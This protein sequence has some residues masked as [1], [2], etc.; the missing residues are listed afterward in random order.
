[1][2]HPRAC[3]TVARFNVRKFLLR[4]ILCSVAAQLPAVLPLSA[5]EPRGRVAP[6]EVPLERCDK[7]PVVGVRVDGTP[8]RFLVDTA[9][10]SF[11]NQR[12]FAGGRRTDVNVSSWS[13]DTK[14]LA[15]EVDVEEFTLGD[16]TLRGLRIPAIELG[17]MEKVCGGHIDG[18]IG[19]D[20][21]ER[22][23]ATI[24]LQKRVAVVA[25]GRAE[26]TREHE[27]R[28][29]VDSCIDLF[30]RADWNHFGD[31][32]DPE[33]VW[34]MRDQDVHGRK[35]LIEYLESCGRGECSHALPQ[36]RIERFWFAGDVAWFEYISR[37]P[38][39]EPEL[40]GMAIVHRD[41]DRWLL[42]NVS[43]SELRARALPAP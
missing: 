6:G 20:L 21:L 27:A 41:G 38:G 14:T 9:A 42:V 34:L 19:V 25:G 43:N 32:V 7:L 1:M 31:C 17:W 4:L 33:V 35:H 13:G 36:V 26:R 11:L 15:R 22:F 37:I 18:V 5:Q 23:G 2:H 10:T 28:G 12:S 40:R 39:Q 3:L 29:F 30:N 8:K 24:D 16:Q